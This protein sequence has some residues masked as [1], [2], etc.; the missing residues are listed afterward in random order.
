MISQYTRNL[1]LKRNE[2]NAVKANVNVE[3]PKS[4]EKTEVIKENLTTEKIEE[5]VKKTDAE[6]LKS[7][8]KE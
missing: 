1:I 8:K 2:E 6:K 3:E 4:V 7:K 5:P